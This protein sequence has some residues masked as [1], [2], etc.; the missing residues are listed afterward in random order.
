MKAAIVV[1]EKTEQDIKIE[2]EQPDY[3][4]NKEFEALIKEAVG[5]IKGAGEVLNLLIE[6][7]NMGF[8]VTSYIRRYP[9]HIHHDLNKIVGAKQVDQ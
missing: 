1:T 4:C 7:E 8:H 3:M 2:I 6:L 5:K 9:N